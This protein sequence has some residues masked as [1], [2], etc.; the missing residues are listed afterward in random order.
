VFA[1]LLVLWLLPPPWGVGR[2]RLL[3]QLAL[4]LT[5][6]IVVARCLLY[7]FRSYV[8]RFLW[9]VRNRMIAVYIFVGLIPLLL[10]LTMAVFGLSLVSGPLSAY[11]VR[12]R[13]EQRAASLQA[14][15]ASLGWDVRGADPEK[16]GE[17]VRAFLAN[18]AQFF[19]RVM[20]RIDTPSRVYAQPTDLANEALP[21]DIKRT[22]AG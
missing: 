3:L 1:V 6:S 2:G 18:S 5:G 21:P 12:A 10:V 9:R 16:R 20:M 7:L 13:V 17:A 19:P 22:K 14:T 8:K 11:M 4:Y 15:A